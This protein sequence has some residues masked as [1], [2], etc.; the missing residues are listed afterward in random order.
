LDLAL[1]TFPDDVRNSTPATDAR[2]DSILP[3]CKMP[4]FFEMLPLSGVEKH[5]D[6]QLTSCLH[7]VTTNVN[8]TYIKSEQMSIF[9]EIT[10]IF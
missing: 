3:K 1:L 5:P 8:F 4:E 2:N 6:F 9:R 7:F 10:D